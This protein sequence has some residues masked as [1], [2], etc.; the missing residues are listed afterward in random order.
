M[1]FYI[2]IF[3]FVIVL[4]LYVHI[5]AQY[6]KS[7]DLEIYEMDYVSNTD[8]QEVC[9]IK[10]PV[11]FEFKNI[12]S[13]VFSDLNLNIL[14]K[15]E[16]FD[17]RVKDTDDVSDYVM[18]KYGSFKGLMETDVKSHFITEGNH[19]FVEDTGL[20]SEFSE[21]NSYLKP[22][23]TVQTKYDIMMGSKEASTP[24]RYHTNDRHFLVVSSGKIHLK[25]SPWKSRKYLH[26]Q[27]DYDNY[28]FRSPLNAWDNSKNT[29]YMNDV[30]KLKFLE[31]DIHPGY[32]LY[33]PP[34][35]WYSVKYSSEPD[36]LV[37][38]ITYNSFINIMANTPD[39]IRYYI[40]QQNTTTKVTRTLV[41]SD[42][43]DSE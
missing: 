43:V 12:N 22:S 42:H 8:L 38:G 35:W 5:I 9:N 31:F 15:H 1:D 2:T 17:V 40:Q 33:I 25:M 29:D 28:E 13:D 32:I 10:Q 37:L 6:K 30:D 19:E 7:E 39:I 36:T 11:L 24:L 41:S 21:L 18:L 14:Q 4:F 20:Y 23:F 34:Y 26:P 16:T 27:V 3:I